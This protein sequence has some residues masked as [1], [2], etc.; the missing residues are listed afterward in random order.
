MYSK[1]FDIMRNQINA[2][3]CRSAWDR[4]VRLYALELIDSMEERSQ[5]DVEPF[6]YTLKECRRWMLNGAADWQQ[7]SEGGCSLCYDVDIAKRLCTPSELKKTDNGRKAPNA[8]ESWIDVQTRALYQAAAR[9]EDAHEVAAQYV[10][11]E[12]QMDLM[13]DAEANV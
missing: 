8:R 2:K 3:R 11:F 12:A 4:G 1:L 5:W 9:V 10:V 13:L 6:P 7:Y